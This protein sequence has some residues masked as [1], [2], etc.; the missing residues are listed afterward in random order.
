MAL[1]QRRPD[2]LSS[3]PIYST[4]QSTTLII[5]GLGN[6]GKQYDGTRHNIGFAAVDALHASQ[7]FEQ[8]TEKK[9]LKCQV[10]QRTIGDN[11]VILCKPT[12]FMNASGEAVQALAH[13]YKVAPEHIVAVHE[14][15]H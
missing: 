15:N 4:G 9:D 3:I 8:W 5:V 2:A 7:D 11:R 12:T 1:F 6:I 14:S 13:F 10:S